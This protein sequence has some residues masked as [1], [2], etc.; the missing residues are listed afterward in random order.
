MKK[1]NIDVQLDNYRFDSTFVK[2][3]KNGLSINGILFK[4][5]KVKMLEFQHLTKYPFALKLL[6]KNK[7]Y[8]VYSTISMRLPG[9]EIFSKPYAE[10]NNAG[11]PGNSGSKGSEEL[12]IED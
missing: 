5:L 9:V 7:S 3:Y 10:S 12:L 8:L 4:P 11:S 6:K 1:Y 2:L